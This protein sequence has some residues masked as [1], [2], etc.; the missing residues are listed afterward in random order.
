MI[1][2]STKFIFSSQSLSIAN[3]ETHFSQFIES[4][5]DPEK[6]TFG[7]ASQTLLTATQARNLAA[8]VEFELA[9]IENSRK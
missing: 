7:A 9:E 4:V 5:G 2:Q 1:G 8:T 3:H 6:G